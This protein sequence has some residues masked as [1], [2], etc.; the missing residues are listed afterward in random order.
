[1][2]PS[3]FL[4]TLNDEI[5]R[6]RYGEQPTELYEPIRYLMAIGGKRLRPVLTLLGAAL[7][8]DDWA[9][10]LRPA[11]AVEVFHNFTLMHDDIMDK[12]PLRR[13]QP[14]VHVKW[15]ENVGI[16][17][18]DVMLVQAYELLLD[19][20]DDLLKPILRR[21]NRTAAQVCEGQQGDM[22][23]EGRS[24]V[25]EADYLE[26]I[27]L[28]TAVLLGFSLELGAMIARAPLAD[29]DLL[30]RVGECI[31]LGFQLKDDY[32]DVYG[33]PGKFGKLVGGDILANKKTFLLIEALEKATGPTRYELTRW[34]AATE[35]N[36]VEKVEAVTA[37]YDQLGIGEA[38]ATLMNR[39]FDQAFSLL[40]QLPV[41]ARRKALLRQFAEQLISRER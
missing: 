8:T 17:S 15:N 24:D 38:T 2:N 31:G 3:L 29:C 6:Q 26:M 27:R 12:A 5:A 22:N 18:G 39:Y 20:D 25:T 28:K 30:R 33:E 35:Y 7:Y 36:P 32:L 19:V 11:M 23:F 10:A 4:Q 9:R 16:L 40:D 41:E 13:G 34:L 21:F 1:M 14:T 37:I